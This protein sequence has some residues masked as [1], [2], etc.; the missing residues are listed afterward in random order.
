MLFHIAQK[1]Q[2]GLNSRLDYFCFYYLQFCSNTTVEYYGESSDLLW[3]V[4]DGE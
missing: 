4:I 3:L 1:S 2:I